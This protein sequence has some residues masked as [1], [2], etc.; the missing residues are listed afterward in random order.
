MKE[1]QEYFKINGHCPVN[2]T[3]KLVVVQW[4]FVKCEYCD[5]EFVLFTRNLVEHFFEVDIF[6]DR[7]N[8]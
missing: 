1:Y 2:G 7:L 8:S 5:Q 4:P 6:Q 3:H